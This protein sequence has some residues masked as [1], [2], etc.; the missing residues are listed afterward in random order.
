MTRFSEDFDRGFF[1][2]HCG[3]D[4]NI[5]G[6]ELY[7]SVAHDKK[8]WAALAPLVNQK[9]PFLDTHTITYRA[10]RMKLK[11]EFLTRKHDRG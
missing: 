7:E 4:T 10:T 2:K 8:K 5:N 9:L 6:E 11:S 3:H 1:Q